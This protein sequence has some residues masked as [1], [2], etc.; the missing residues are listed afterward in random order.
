V[1]CWGGG[2]RVVC[3]PSSSLRDR[4]A[5]AATGASTGV[6]MPVLVP[7]EG[8]VHRPWPPNAVRGR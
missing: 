6:A 8:G 3:A 7:G 5:M 2:A 4:R 1:L